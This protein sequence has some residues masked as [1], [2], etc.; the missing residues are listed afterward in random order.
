MPIAPAM[1]AKTPTAKTLT[2]K[3]LTAKNLVPLILLVFV[4]IALVADWLDWGDTAVFVTSALAIIPASIWLSNATEKVAAVTGATLGGLVNALFG[5]ATAL[6]IALMALRRGLVDIVEASITGS[7]LSALLLL[8]G[9]AM[10][11]GGLRYKEQTFQPIVARVNGS[12]MTL[13]SIAL[14]LPS[15]VIATSNIVDQDAIRS[16]S[17]IISVLLIL[18]YGLTLIFS[19]VTHS[20]LYDGRLIE[21]EQL[22]EVEQAK[23][24]LWLWIGVLLSSTIAIA[25]ISD[26]FVGVIEVETQK[27]GLTPLFTGVI[28]LPL[29]SDI[30]GYIILIRLALKNEMDLAVSTVTGDSSLV[31]LFIAPVLILVGLAIGQPIDLNFNPFEVVAIAIS[32]IVANLISSGGRSNWLDGALLLATYVA[33]GVAFYYHP[34]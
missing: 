20:Y 23:K 8:L 27:L 5:N 29:I 32:V 22:D 25:F 30:S 13:A 26:L 3:T 2:A 18:V 17:I 4:P 1:T 31:A 15:A 9:L 33:L 12:S 10:F 16:L 19:F 11:T 34:V 21:Q 14:A 7:I 28:L 6:I 24:N